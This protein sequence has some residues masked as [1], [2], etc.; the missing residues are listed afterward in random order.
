MPVAS[1]LFNATNGL[2]G[3]LEDYLGRWVVLYFYPKD[4]TP[5]CTLESQ[6][7]RDHHQAFVALN[8]VVFGISRDSL[9]SHDKFKAQQSLSFELVS[10]TDEALCQQFGVIKM[11]SMY[12]KEVRGIERSTFIIDPQGNIRQ[13]WRKVTVK[14]HVEEVLHTL[15]TL[16]G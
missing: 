12:G 9:T 11:K 3:H 1:C 15:K 16:I 10:D 7:F 8:T 2:T 6:D 4:A 5:G 14:G 13:E